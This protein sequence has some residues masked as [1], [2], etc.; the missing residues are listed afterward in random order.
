MAEGH[1]MTELGSV[2]VDNL[3][4]DIDL[5]SHEMWIYI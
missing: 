1:N 4:S 3:I 5:Y 2:H